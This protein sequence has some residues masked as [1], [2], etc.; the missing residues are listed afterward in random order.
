MGMTSR[1]EFDENAEVVLAAKSVAFGALAVLF[2]A[3]PT[4]PVLEAALSPAVRD[5]FAVAVGEDSAAID[6]Q[7]DAPAT[8]HAVDSAAALFDKLAEAAAASTD[9]LNSEYMRLFVGPNAPVAP[10]WES[11]YREPGRCLYNAST[12]AVET[13]YRELPFTCGDTPDGPK[14]HVAFECAFLSAC[15]Q[16]ALDALSAGNEAE[17]TRCCQVANRFVR[18]HL[19]RWVPE[20]AQSA[21]T[22]T[23]PFYTTATRLLANLA[24]PQA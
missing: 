6:E 4:E 18:D 24:T 2:Q 20:F 1:N 8:S 7:G 9:S 3:E 15:F 10:P 23:T 19:S 22:E 12:L 17:A 5:A 13:A 11:V 14:D 21:D 16:R